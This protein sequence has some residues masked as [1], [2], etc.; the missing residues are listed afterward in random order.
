MEAEGGLFPTNK[1]LE[2]WKCFVPQTAC[3][4]LLNFT[5]TF[6]TLGKGLFNFY[7]LSTLT[8][9]EGRLFSG[10][11]HSQHHQA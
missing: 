1:T 2:T 6:L 5:L 7:P 10:I 8:L 9:I 4:V 3:R 11:F